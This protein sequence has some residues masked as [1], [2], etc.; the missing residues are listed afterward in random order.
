MCGRAVAN[1][2]VEVVVR[3][4]SV[5]NYRA[6]SSLSEDHIDPGSILQEIP[7]SSPWIATPS[8]LS[9][10]LSHG[11]AGRR[12][13]IRRLFWGTRRGAWARVWIF[14]GG[15]IRSFGR[16]WVRRRK[17]IVAIF[18]LIEKERKRKRVGRGRGSGVHTLCFSFKCCVLSRSYVGSS[19]LLVKVLNGGSSCEGARL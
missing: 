13:T 10:R 17:R 7:H 14:R 4:S 18:A 5:R 12:R 6:S 8:V 16:R 15:D 1:D 3:R 11:R 9:V 19:R 2:L